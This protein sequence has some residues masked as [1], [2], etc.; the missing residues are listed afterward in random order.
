MTISLDVIITNSFY[1]NMVDDEKR[2]AIWSKMTTVA[3][4]DERKYRLDAC[5][6]LMDWDK[7][8]DRQNDNGWEV[9]HVV[10]KTLL[11]KKEVPEDEI[12][13][14]INLRPMQWQNNDSK[15][16]DYPEYQ[17]SVKYE[18]GKNVAQNGVYEVNKELQRILQNKYSKY[19]L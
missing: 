17:A 2:V 6:A 1:N 10:P 13:D 8:G 16:S 3:G 11:S 7:Y 19:G 4:K 18:G 12:D 5:G 9:D 15:S 14:E